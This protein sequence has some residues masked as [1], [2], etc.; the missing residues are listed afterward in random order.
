MDDFHDY[1]INS[2]DVIELFEELV[3]HYE[4]DTDD[5]I[6]LLEDEVNELVDVLDWK[7]YI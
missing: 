3:K 7:G 1:L 6:M 2:Y 4:W 5:I